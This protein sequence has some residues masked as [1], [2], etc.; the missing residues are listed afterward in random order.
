LSAREITRA[1]ECEGGEIPYFYYCSA[2]L[3]I[4]RGASIAKER[5]AASRES[6]GS[7]R[8]SHLRLAANVFPSPTPALLGRSA[9]AHLAN[10]YEAAAGAQRVPSKPTQ[11]HPQ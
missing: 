9:R 8:G 4:Y 10:Y 7:R 11:L 5:E 3:P 6:R 2:V 1:E